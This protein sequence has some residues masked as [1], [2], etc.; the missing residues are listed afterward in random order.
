[1]PTY[2]HVTQDNPPT[3]SA[4]TLLSTIS[5]RLI[6]FILDIPLATQQLLLT[7]I[8]L[9]ILLDERA[10]STAAVDG[11]I[12]DTAALEIVLPAHVSTLH[13]EHRERQARD[14][15]AEASEQAGRVEPVVAFEVAVLAQAVVR[16]AEGYGG[17]AAGE[18]AW[19]G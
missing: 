7:I 15:A 14:D 19:G 12:R 2:E 18:Q 10:A 5:H 6:N 11:S 9:L 13:G 16:A 3:L 1:M 17:A 4:F 8:S